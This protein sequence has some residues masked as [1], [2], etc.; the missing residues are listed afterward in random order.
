MKYAFMSFSAP[1]LKLDELLELAARIGY[2]GIEPRIGSNHAHGIELDISA[3][4][5]RAIRE[6]V[7][8][9]GVALCCVATGCKYADPASAP[10]MVE[11]TRRAIALA[12]DLGVPRL[13]VFGG[14]IGQGLPRTQAIELVADSLGAVAEEAQQHNVTI[15][16]ETHD[17][18]TD[19]EH[20]AE[21][22]RRV[23]SPAVAVNWDYQHT[24]R[25]AGTSVDQAFTTLQ[26]WI[27]HVHFH[28]GV[29]RADKLIFLPVGA[30]DYDNRRVIELLLGT[31][32][33]GYLSGEW[34]DWEPYDIHLPR[35]L[36]AMKGLEQAATGATA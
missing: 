25:I 20:V 19:P 17:D 30:G 16:L 29:N 6:Q 35:E 1:Q 32:Y 2:D 24:T 15:C 21:V 7:A 10:G 33:S 28:D 23:D 8:A 27:K 14:A 5:R 26:P 12:A 18:W 3:A 13:R 22:L 34:I 11:D 9:S 4:Q 36:A 31:S